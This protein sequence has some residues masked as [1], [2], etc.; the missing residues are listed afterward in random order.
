M[1]KKLPSSDLAMFCKVKIK[2]LI[3]IQQNTNSF[4]FLVKLAHENIPKTVPFFM[5]NILQIKS[6]IYQKPGLI[7]VKKKKIHVRTEERATNQ[8]S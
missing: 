5:I 1:M 6:Q 7:Q 3:S 2:K 8:N 4:L